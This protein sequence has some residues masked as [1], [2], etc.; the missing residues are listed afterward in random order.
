M[1]ATGQAC[2]ALLPTF[3]ARLEGL[4]VWFMGQF[5]LPVPVFQ[6]S[7]PATLP[8]NANYTLLLGF[9]WG[10]FWKR[11]DTHEILAFLKFSSLV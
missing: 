1:K 10:F 9:G 4:S 6:L 5:S 2:S 7:L 8:I 3:R 11:G